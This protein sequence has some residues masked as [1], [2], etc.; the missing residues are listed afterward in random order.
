MNIL[1]WRKGPE[2]TPVSP[3]EYSYLYDLNIA[4]KI[5]QQHPTNVLSFTQKSDTD[6]SV[7]CSW[8]D[9]KAWYNLTPNKNSFTI[10]GSDFMTTVQRDNIVGW[11][12]VK[13]KVVK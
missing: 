7:E 10:T 6:A 12:I 2:S 3:V 1:W 9:F 4:L 8:E 11:N 13:H 5:K